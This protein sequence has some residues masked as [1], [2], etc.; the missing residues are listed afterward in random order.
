[1][2]PFIFI[3]TSLLVYP[4]LG[5][6]LIKYTKDRHK[7][8]T[9]ILRF[10][11]SASIIVLAAVALNL[12]TISECFNWFCLTFIYCTVSTTIWH[13]HESQGGLLTNL[14]VYTIFG[15]GYLMATLGFLFILIFSAEM[16]AVQSKWLTSELIYKERNIGSGPDPSIRLKQIEIYKQI[17]WFPLLAKKFSE[18][19]Y[20]EWNHPLQPLLDISVS[21]DSKKLYMKSQVE[22]YKVWKWCDSITLEKPN[23]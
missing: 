15:F 18:I 22:G 2:L 12:I 5:R 20:D 9:L 10:L 8:R 11:I 14:L 4:V 7:L 6:G 1:M 21:Q 23:L 3:T 19:E 17:R 16:E 13:L